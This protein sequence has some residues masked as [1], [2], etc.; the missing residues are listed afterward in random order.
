MSLTKTLIKAAGGAL[1]ALAF[2]AGMASATPWR[3]DYVQTDLGTGSHQYDFLLTLDNNDNSWTLGQGFD[4]FVIGDVSSSGPATFTEGPAFFTSIPT[5]ALATSSG[6]GSNGPTLGFVDGSVSG[7]QLVP[8]A[9]GFSVA[10]SGVSSYA[11]T[12]GTLR[13]SHLVG[14]TATI[15][16]VANQV[17]SFDT[18]PIPLPAGLPLLLGALGAA[19]FVARRKGRAQA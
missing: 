11:Y 16:A 10:F 13:F 18:S 8:D 17:A 12:S 19:G 1:V 9:V 4:W 14:N 2:A 3:L 7:L 15:R 5:G 6:G